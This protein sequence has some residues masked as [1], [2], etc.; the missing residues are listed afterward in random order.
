MHLCINV[1]T[2][3][4]HKNIHRYSLSPSTHLITLSGKIIEQLSIKVE[5]VPW[6]IYILGKAKKKSSSFTKACEC[7]EHIPITPIFVPNMAASFYSFLFK[8]KS[9]RF[10]DRVIFPS[11]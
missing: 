2:T 5:I 9:G 7:P 6:E 11:L 3:R 4:R 10:L 1:F 8:L